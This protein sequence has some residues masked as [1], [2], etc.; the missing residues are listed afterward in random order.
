VLPLHAGG[1]VPFLGSAG[2]VDEPDRAQALGL[3]GLS[4]QFGG[5][6]LVPLPDRSEVPEVV[7]QELLERA[8]RGAGLEGDGLAGL[9]LQVGEQ[10][11]DV[12]VQVGEGLGVAATEQV[13][14]QLSAQGRSQGAQLCL[15]HQSHAQQVEGCLLL[16]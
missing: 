6:L 3:V 10:A 7:T 1:L 8:D 5:M 4:E 13:A 11:A 15:S 2:F 14:V 9:A 16:L 12:G